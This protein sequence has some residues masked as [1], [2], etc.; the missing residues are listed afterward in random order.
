MKKP[1]H[2]TANDRRVFSC[3][4]SQCYV[5]A[6]KFKTHAS[7]HRPKKQRCF[8]GGQ[9]CPSADIPFFNLCAYFIFNFPI[10]SRVFQ[11]TYEQLKQQILSEELAAGQRLPATRAIASE[12][13]LILNT[14]ISAYQQLKVEGYVKSVTGS[15]YYVE[16]LDLFERDCQEQKYCNL[17]L[18]LY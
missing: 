3:F 6:L 8:G 9:P 13:H 5:T 17:F 1:L 18:L 14:I 15:G 10:P 2:H 16:N 4:N 12:Y 11:V 7:I